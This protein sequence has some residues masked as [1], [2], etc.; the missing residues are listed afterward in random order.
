MNKKNGFILLGITAVLLLVVALFSIFNWDT[1]SYLFNQMSSGVSIAGEYILGLGW[2]GF[3]AISLIIVVCFFVPV[4]SSIPVQL[5]S[6]VSYGLP[7]ATIHVILSIFIAS[8]FAFLFTRCFRVFSTKKQIE[9]RIKMEEQIKNSN[10]S[11]MYFLV[12]AYLAPFVPFLLIHT[13]AASS[14]I[15][16]WKYSLITLIGPIPDVIV[17]LWLGMKVT[18]SSPIVSY[19][20]LLIIVICVILSFTFKEK[21]MNIIFGAKK[22]NTDGQ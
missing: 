10:R 9:K 22:E 16:W 1:V 21:I 15:K 6:V 2:V 12:F 17:T 5:A 18:S 13:V 11:V 7:I 14:G 8:Q 3:A 4:I 20:T 19:I